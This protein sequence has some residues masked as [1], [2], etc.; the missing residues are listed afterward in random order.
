MEKKDIYQERYKSHQNR[1]KGQLIDILNSR[2]SQRIF[3]GKEITE[4][5]LTYLLANMA[6]VP[7]SCSRQAI[8]AVVIDQ[9]DRKDLLSGILV[10]GVGWIHR[11]SKVILLFANPLAYK[12]GKEIKFMP[13]LDAGVVLQTGY[14][15]CED[16]GI[17]CC[18]VNPSVRDEYKFIFNK[19]FN[20]NKHI[21]CGAL[22]VGNYNHKAE[23]S[24]KK[25]NI[26]TK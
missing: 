23:K 22:A 7:S 11:A 9:R 5:E 12:A 3:N 6:K 14:L 15:L 4:K 18:F 25:D 20:K 17:G 10:G 1:K 2:T 24:Q 8:F 19:F 13:F 21:F 16:R 26:K